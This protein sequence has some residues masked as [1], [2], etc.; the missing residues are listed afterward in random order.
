[1]Y[2]AALRR[3]LEAARE[4]F[5][6][7][8]LRTVYLGGG[9]PSLLPPDLA[10]EVLEGVRDLF[11]VEPGA[12]VTLEANPASTDPDRLAAWREG[13]VNRLSIGVQGFDA[14]VLAVLERRTDGAQGARAFR[15]ARD[16]G[17][18]NISL[19]L[20]FGV[21]GQSLESWEDTVRSAM[22]LGPEHLSCYCLT[23]EPGT[24]LTRRRDAGRLREVDA[25]GQWDLLDHAD[26]QLAQGGWRRY[27]VSS[28]ARPGFRSRHNR[29]YWACRSVYGAGAG[30]HSYAT[31]GA[32]GRARRWWNAARPRDYIAASRAPEAGG[33]DLDAPLAR[34][35]RVLLGLRTVTGLR[36]P[37]GL[38]SELR[39]L[40]AAGLV[41]RRDFWVAPTRRGLDLHNQIALAV[42]P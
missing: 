22:A 14:T 11:T 33:E 35:E 9:T 13:G 21:P 26:R 19:D 31:W 20:I 5:P 39:E 8:A 18:R 15:Q 25:D 12:E 37:A 36:A 38:E 30:A 17:F 34:A 40:E 41:R 3:E 23:F 2:V 10:A 24:L 4:R 6:F 7:G 28:W 27:E 29:A 1:E 32:S 42:L 16:A